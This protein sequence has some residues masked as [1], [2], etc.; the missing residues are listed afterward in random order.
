MARCHKAQKDSN[1]H[2][3]FWK[4][5]GFT[6]E[7]CQ[8]VQSKKGTLNLRKRSNLQRAIVEERDYEQFLLTMNE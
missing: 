2:K 3:S 8:Y 4:Q 5:N 6:H 1:S 7:K